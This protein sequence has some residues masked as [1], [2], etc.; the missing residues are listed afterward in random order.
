RGIFDFFGDKYVYHESAND[1]LWATTYDGG[2]GPVKLLEDIF[3]MAKGKEEEY[4]NLLQMTR[5][6]R[7]IVYSRLTD[8]YGDVPYFE[9]GKGYY[10][11]IF[12]PK[13][14]SE[15]RRV[16]KECRERREAGE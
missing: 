7:T 1:N 3:Y 16:G 8:L 9:A 4:H 2:T 12:K 5:I 15:E 14:R 13:Y 6:W 10:E 11:Q